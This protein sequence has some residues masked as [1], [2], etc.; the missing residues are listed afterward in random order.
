MLTNSQNQATGRT[1]QPMINL[2][3]D[4]PHKN[5][6]SPQYNINPTLIFK[7]KKKG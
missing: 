2:L 3:P 7:K 6:Y 4:S 1:Y 5:W